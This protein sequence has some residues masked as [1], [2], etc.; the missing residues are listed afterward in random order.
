MT[1]TITRV[2]EYRGRTVDKMSKLIR[3]GRVP[4]SIAQIMQKRLET[5]GTSKEKYWWD[6]G[7]DTGDAIVYHPDGKIKICNY[8]DIIK[9]VNT[10]NSKNNNIRDGGLI[11]SS[12]DD[13]GSLVGDTFSR[14]DCKKY[15]N[16]RY[17]HPQQIFDNP[18]WIKLAG[19][20]VSLLKEYALADFQI[21]NR[22]KN[23]FH[24]R[25]FISLFNYRD[26]LVD[27]RRWLYGVLEK[28][29]MTL[30]YVS[31]GDDSSVY[32]NKLL[33]NITQRL[34]GVRKTIAIETRS[35][36]KPENQ[37]YVS[38]EKLSSILNHPYSAE[39]DSKK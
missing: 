9:L 22:N 7:F 39:S 8:R 20:D 30:C 12:N 33:D 16:H 24:L 2:K 4:I 3:S 28:P 19:G 17:E 32:A 37:S 13:Y 15:G 36:R 31:P 1:N 18:L 10:I 11:I 21:A 25:M 34:I 35:S 23:Y 5:F 6:N 26:D 27:I 38:R 14:E 29:V